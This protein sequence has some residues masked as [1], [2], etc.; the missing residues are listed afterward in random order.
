[1][2]ISC[3]L[4]VLNLLISQLDVDIT[5]DQ[6]F[7]AHK[8]LSRQVFSKFI[9]LFI[10]FDQISTDFDT[11]CRDI[12]ARDKIS[13]SNNNYLSCFQRSSQAGS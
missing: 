3:S 8:N 11:R 2:S 5:K 9:G 13:I 4:I 6:S 12:K 10:Y 1:M 7:V